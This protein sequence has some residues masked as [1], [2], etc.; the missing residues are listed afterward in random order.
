MFSG[1]NIPLFGNYCLI[2]GF[3]LA[4]LVCDDVLDGK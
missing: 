3:H 1:R 2:Q 4:A